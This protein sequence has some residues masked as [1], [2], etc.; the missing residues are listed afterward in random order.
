MT[1]VDN[2]IKLESLILAVTGIL[3]YHLSMTSFALTMIFLM[4]SVI[5]AA[6]VIW[7]HTK[8]GKKWLKDL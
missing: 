8:S 2:P 1:K 3:L 5:G 6:L 7:S 4:T